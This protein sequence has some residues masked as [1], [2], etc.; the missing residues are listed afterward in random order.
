MGIIFRKKQAQHCAVCNRELGRH[1]YRPDKGWNMQGLLCSTC[2]VEKTKEF[3]LRDQL[4]EQAPDTCA[5]CRKE[6]TSDADRN[7]PKWQW[8]MESGL[9]VCKSCYAKKDDNYSKKMNSCSVCNGRLGMFYYH[10]KPTWNIE[11][12]LCRKCWDDRNSR[13]K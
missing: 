5:I 2:H 9:L 1:K 12:N 7:K 8:E 11:G 3:M 6:I 4:A 13:G 10:P